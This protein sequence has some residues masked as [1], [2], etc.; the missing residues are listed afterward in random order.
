MNRGKGNQKKLMSSLNG[1]MLK[2]NRKEFG[3]SHVLT[4]NTKHL[5]SFSTPRKGTDE[6]GRVED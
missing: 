5:Y 6:A 2:G 4:R 3:K 1:P